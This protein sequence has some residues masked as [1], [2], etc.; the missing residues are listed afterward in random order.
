[1]LGMIII[2]LSFGSL[3]GLI[4]QK[5]NID[6]RETYANSKITSRIEPED[7]FF[8]LIRANED[9][10]ES[11]LIGY[12]DKAHID[13]C[14]E[15]I[16]KRSFLDKLPGDLLLAWGADAGEEG[17]PL[18]ALRQ[19]KAKGSGPDVTDIE[20]LEV[21]SDSQNSRYSLLISFNP[22][23]TEKWSRLTGANIGRDIAIVINDRV[24]SAPRVQEQINMG[25]CMI[26]GNFDQDEV[27]E[28]K[29]QLVQIR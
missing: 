12:C 16:Q 15:Y 7:Q 1:M 6:F 21:V 8:R 5:G 4:A 27:V 18:Y 3:S 17:L 19:P 13:Q 28:L 2:V 14:R 22:D 9:E 20:Q 29:N 10:Q 23:G 26:T 25:K 11:S 24:W